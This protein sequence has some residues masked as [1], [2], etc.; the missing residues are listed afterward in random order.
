M[1][2]V[3]SVDELVVDPVVGFSINMYTHKYVCKHSPL[4]NVY[5]HA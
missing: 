2:I 3:L 1:L 4:R 5:L